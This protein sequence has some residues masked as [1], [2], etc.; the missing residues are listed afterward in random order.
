MRELVKKLRY[1]Y[2][3][4]NFNFYEG[5]MSEK[6]LKADIKQKIHR[7]RL[8]ATCEM[9]G[10]SHTYPVHASGAIPQYGEFNRAKLLFAVADD[11]ERSLM[12]GYPTLRA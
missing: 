3:S 12:Y 2:R 5:S 11:L 6:N 7:L 1:L 9:V 4:L 10:A 8:E